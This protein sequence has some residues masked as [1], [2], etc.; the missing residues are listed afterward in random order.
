MNPE[1]HSSQEVQAILDLFDGEINIFEREPE[2]LLKIKKM[3]N[4]KYLDSELTIKKE[5]LEG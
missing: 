1:M 5:N 3:V 4:Q 2:K